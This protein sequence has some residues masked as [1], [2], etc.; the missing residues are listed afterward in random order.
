MQLKF[1]KVET[2][3]NK[4]FGLRNNEYLKF[5]FPESGLTVNEHS[6]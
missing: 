4:V 2:L 5:Y 3:L 1:L 6:E